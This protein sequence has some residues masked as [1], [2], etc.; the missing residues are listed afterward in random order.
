MLKNNCLSAD[1]AKLR[2]RLGFI[3]SLL[4]A[5]FGKALL[6]PITRRQYTHFRKKPQLNAELRYCLKWRPAALKQKTPLVVPLKPLPTIDV[7]S[8][9]AGG[10]HLGVFIAINGSFPYAHSH[11]P[12][13][14]RELNLQIYEFGNVCYHTSDSAG[15]D[16]GEKC[17]YNTLR[18]QYWR[19]KCTNRR[20]FNKPGSEPN[21]CH[22]LADCSPEQ[23]F[24]LGR[25]CRLSRKHCRRSV[26]QM[27]HGQSNEY[28][29]RAS[30]TSTTTQTVC[31]NL[32]NAR[33]VKGR[34]LP[35]SP[36]GG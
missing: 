15:C 17:N 26:T 33:S 36:T 28:V 35:Y 11:T 22:F 20:K 12:E 13:W 31:A 8:D 19:A 27:R 21:C 14:S 10:G 3:Q 5:G 4:F 30:Q 24:C 6:R 32:T 16:D 9:A 29:H 7:Y 34:P 18:G 23:Y 1:A 25:T 2:G